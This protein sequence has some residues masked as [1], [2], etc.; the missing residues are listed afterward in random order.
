MRITIL[1]SYYIV[2]ICLFLV[3]S[4]EHS[5]AVYDYVG[6]KG[7]EME[8]WA[9][10]KRTKTADEIRE[11]YERIV[12]EKKKK[13]FEQRTNQKGIVSVGVNMSDFFDD[14]EIDGFPSIE[15][16]Q[17]MMSQ[18]IDAPLTDRDTLTLSGTMSVSNGTGNGTVGTAMRHVISAKTW[19]E[20]EFVVGQGPVLAFKGF[21]N[22]TNRCFVNGQLMFH[23]SSAG[24]RPGIQAG[25]SLIK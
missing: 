3:L 2:F 8:G 13:R 19:T 15:V 10:V 1:Y 18:S 24:V 11:E 23:V 6:M 21:R 14:Q 20:V 7:L 16:T 4:D 5:R 9:V 12:N 25:E 17:M 22:L